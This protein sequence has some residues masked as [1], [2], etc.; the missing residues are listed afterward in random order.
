MLHCKDEKAKLDVAA[1][2]EEENEK[3]TQRYDLQVDTLNSTWV[4]KLQDVVVHHE[5]QLLEVRLEGARLENRLQI[6]IGKNVLRGE[7]TAPIP[8]SPLT[9]SA[10]STSL[11]LAPS[12]AT[13]TPTPPPGDTMD[14]SQVSRPTTTV[15]R[16]KEANP[17]HPISPSEARPI[18]R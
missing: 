1:A 13:S 18:H 12:P 2:R 17:T 6:E 16:K 7:K 15:P 11:G 10:P 4:D 14:T 8:I 9:S 5:K 3:W